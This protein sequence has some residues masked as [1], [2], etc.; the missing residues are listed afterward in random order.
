MSTTAHDPGAQRRIG[1]TGGI[2]SGKSSV[3]RY[4]AEQGVP[5]FD[6]DRY[7]HD[8]LAPG[9]E[10]S[11]TVL[12]RYGTQVMANPR[13]DTDTT[14]AH[15]SIN[16]RALGEIVFNNP[17]ER[18]WLEQLVHPLVRE[19]FQ[20]DFNEHDQ[21]DAVV[22]M[23]P[24]LFEAGLTELCSEIWVVNCTPE[25][26]LERLQRRDGLDDASA[27]ARINAQWP[28]SQKCKLADLV[29]DNCGEAARWQAQILEQMP[30]IG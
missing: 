14:P 5:V 6:A 26:Q 13:P 30:R 16:R 4:L 19:R 21:A 15:R 8:A 23:I 17:S 20:Q 29:L 22:L 2:A 9:S 3:G 28:L 11:E 10:A 12:E 7:A 1:L 27:R 24:L 25:Q 18:H